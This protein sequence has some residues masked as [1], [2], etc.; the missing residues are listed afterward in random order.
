MHATMYVDPLS[1][2]L[3]VSILTVYRIMLIDLYERPYS[4][5]AS[6]SRAFIDRILALSGPDGGVVGGED[7]IST[8]RPLKDGGREAWDMI[9]RLRQK[10]WQKAGLNPQMLWTEQ[11][12]IQAGVASPAGESQNLRGSYHSA[13]SPVSGSP[14]PSS[15]SQSQPAAPDRQL[16]DFNRMFYNMTRTHVHPSASMSSSTVKPSPLRYS[17]P[18]PERA[19]HSMPAAQYN[20]NPAA[21]TNPSVLTSPS[22]ISSSPDVTSSLGTPPSINSSAPL[23]QTQPQMPHPPLP[24]PH[25]DNSPRPFMAPISP[26]PMGV[27][28]PPSMVDP[29]L[30]FDWDQ[31]DAVFGQ[32]LPV[33]DELMELDPVSGLEFSNLGIPTLNPNN[34]NG[35]GNT[36]N[37]PTSWDN[38]SAGTPGNWTGYC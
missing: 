20:S 9:R 14:M 34:E 26:T 30:N 6:R 36:G 1:M 23:P 28:T 25:S 3:L 2:M 13:A 7:G 35:I 31:W 27:P 22:V 16:N 33:A 5:E 17:Y 18:P 32:H 12:Q 38:P 19:A 15:A 37:G 29:N 4:P 8:Q 10:A 21:V 11:D 24:L